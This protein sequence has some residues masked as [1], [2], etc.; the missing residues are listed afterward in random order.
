MIIEIITIYLCAAGLLGFL[1][2]VRREA[3]REGV[4][5]K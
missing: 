4:W 2:W 1:W 5:K 3:K